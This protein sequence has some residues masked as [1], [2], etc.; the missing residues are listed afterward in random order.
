M[1]LETLLFLAFFLALPLL[2]RLVRALRARLIAAV[3][4]A[5]PADRPGPPPLAPAERQSLPAVEPPP[6]PIAVPAPRHPAQ[7]SRGRLNRPAEPE[8]IEQPTRRATR[9]ARSRWNSRI[10]DRRRAVV[11]MTI[12]GPCRALDRDAAGQR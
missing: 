10:G 5:T 12:L 2:D 8:S 9:G 11:L 3:E 1:T 6:I 4:Q 7:A